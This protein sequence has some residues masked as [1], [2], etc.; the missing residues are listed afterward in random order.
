MKANSMFTIVVSI[1]CVTFIVAGFGY[2]KIAELGQVTAT[3]VVKLKDE[4]AELKI[5]LRS[6]ETKV[7]NFESTDSAT[8][9][10]VEVLEKRIRSTEY[11]LNKIDKELTNYFD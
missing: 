7:T 2:Y 11:K 10:S 6:F 5:E 3:E 8:V 4:V 9:R 1:I